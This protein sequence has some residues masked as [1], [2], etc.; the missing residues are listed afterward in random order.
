[1]KT[2]LQGALFGV[3]MLGGIAVLFGAAARRSTGA[4]AG[5]EDGTHRRRSR[6]G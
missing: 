6:S 4:G 2:Y 1:M 3:V 5:I